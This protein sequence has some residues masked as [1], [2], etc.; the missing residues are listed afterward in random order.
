MATWSNSAARKRASE[1]AA[2]RLITEPQWFVPPASLAHAVRNFWVLDASNATGLAEERI[3]PDGSVALVFALGDGDASILARGPLSVGHTLAFSAS[4]SYVAVRLRAGIA[5]PLLAIDAASLAVR[6]VA[7]T[8]L[9]ASNLRREL[10]RLDLT[11]APLEVLTAIQ[12]SLE[13]TIE[14]RR[15]SR[16]TDLSRLAMRIE[17]AGR[18]RS[19]HHLASQLGTSERTLRRRMLAEVGL[20]PK[21]Y[22]RTVRL[23]S[24]L[25]A[26]A[27]DG[28]DMAAS[29]AIEVGYADQAHMCREFQQML[30]C[31]PS[32]SLSLPVSVPLE[33][34]AICTGSSPIAD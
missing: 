21:R 27:H 30:G 18:P 10:Q 3:V 6:R 26:L 9:P 1:R 28:L 19:I 14:Q 29:I 13:R 8:D 11:Q 17:T 20:T 5:A 16:G 4:R 23:Q 24:A 12:R 15:L 25:C 2:P 33:S 34:R 7:L 32:A 22:L 31:A